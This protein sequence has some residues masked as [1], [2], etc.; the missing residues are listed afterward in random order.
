M[1]YEKN[2]FL[3]EIHHFKHHNFG[4]LCWSSHSKIHQNHEIRLHGIWKLSHVKITEV[5]QAY[6]GWSFLFWL[7]LLLSLL[8]RRL[9][10]SLDRR[11]LRH[12]G[13]RSRSLSLQGCHDSQLKPCV[14]NAKIEMFVG[15][16]SLGLSYA[17]YIASENTRR[18][19]R[20]IVATW[21]WNNLS[22]YLYVM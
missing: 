1:F 5:P 16:I 6:F 3:I 2:L 11:L 20:I 4:D 9:R 7:G 15:C 12:L 21:G 10:R 8:C 17:T 19:I 22:I 18:R 13:A 14:S